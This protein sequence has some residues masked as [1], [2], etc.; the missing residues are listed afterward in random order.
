MK[1]LVERSEFIGIDATNLLHCGNCD[2]VQLGFL[3][4]ELDGGDVL[5]RGAFPTL[6]YFTLNNAALLARS[7]TYLKRLLA[8]ISQTGSLPPADVE[9]RY[10]LAGHRPARR[11]RHHHAGRGH[12]LEHAV[13]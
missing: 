9:G 4:E 6:P 13:S 10:A 3:A 8:Q 5:F 7:N 2:L 1:Q 11:S 12:C